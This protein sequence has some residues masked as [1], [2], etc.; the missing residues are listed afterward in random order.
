MLQTRPRRTALTLAAAL[1]LF[2]FIVVLFSLP[3]PLGMAQA[4]TPGS[5]LGPPIERAP[6]A[7]IHSTMSL[8]KAAIPIPKKRVLLRTTSGDLVHAYPPLTLGRNEQKASSGAP[9]ILMLH[10]MCG[11]PLASCDYWNRG[12]RQ[13]NWLLCPSGNTRC[14]KQH[15]D[16][17]RGIESRGPHLGEVVESL[18][19]RFGA[20]IDTKGG[21]ILM[22]FSRGAFVARDA[23]YGA[24]K[25]SY[26]ALVLIGAAIKLDALQLRQAGI[27]RVVMA[28]G[29]FDGARASMR[30]ST[31][32]LNAA[33]LPTRFVSTGR[34][35]HQ[36]PRDFEA[37]VR[38]AIGWI[39][40]A[41][42]ATMQPAAA[43]GSGPRNC[44]AA[45]SGPL[46]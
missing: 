2:G 32:K 9:V 46:G 4:A 8:S 30:A 26:R 15:F 45:A 11:E 40:Q 43:C 35:Y 7:V 37:F 10:G 16:W 1:G 23:V 29:D 14:G 42:I 13:G 31:T 5:G 3:T 24:P 20:H 28:C 22:G 6:R 19:A 41:P 27:Q 44:V 17:A 38:S 34:I 39:N 21:S 12:G 25:G 36:L 18:G 33:G